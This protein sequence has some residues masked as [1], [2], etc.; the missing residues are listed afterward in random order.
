M[1]LKQ[2]VILV[3]EV[4]CRAVGRSEN[5]VSTV[6]FGAGHRIKGLR[7]GKRMSSDGLE[8]GLAW[9]SS[10]WPPEVEWPSQVTRPATAPPDGQADNDS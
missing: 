7:Q 4:Y 8:D 6:V 5:R 2:Q 10:H 9:F 1:R 3:S